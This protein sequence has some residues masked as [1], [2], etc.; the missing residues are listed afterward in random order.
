MA[1]SDKRSDEPRSSRLAYRSVLPAFLLILAFAAVVTVLLSRDLGRNDLVGGDEGYYGV[2]ARNILED[3]SY[4]INPSLSPLGRPGD[5]PFLYP[6]ILSASLAM[7]GIGEVPLRMVSLVASVLTGLL[8]Y[9]TACLLKDNRTGI[10]SALIYLSTPLIANTGRQVA[11]EPVLVTFSMA[12]VF[13]F[14]LACR[15]DRLLPSFIAG[16]FFGA[17]FLCK[18]WL[19]LIPAFGV[20][21]GMTLY[22]LAGSRSEEWDYRTFPMLISLASG[23]LA[24]GSMQLVL[25]AIFTPGNLGHWLDV[26]FGFSLIS[27]ATGEGFASYWHRPWHFYLVTLAR[28]L[29]LWLPLLCIGLSALV[30]SRRRSPSFMIFA[31]WALP[32]IPMSILPVKSGGYI[33][34]FVPVLIIAAGVGLMTIIN[35]DPARWRTT[36]LVST[37]IASLLV[38]SSQVYLPAAGRP[39]LH[40]P[41]IFLIQISWILAMIIATYFRSVFNIRAGIVILGLLFMTMAAGLYRDLEITK[42]VDHATG[43]RSIA[44]SA[45]PILSG[46]DP[47]TPCFIS[48]EWPAI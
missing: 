21:T 35:L 18:L 43:Y 38:L 2:M 10:Y 32:L 29:S 33:L 22:G 11:A 24:T 14:L 19:A 6:L 30:K 41:A 26:Y 31:A 17:A 48:P 9:L 13:L 20:V 42:S 4:I 23:F 47:A 40:S 44:E 1:Y 27:R 5:K 15:R 45:A 3:P 12:G 36:L 8:I 39:V 25:C 7:G 28:S 46:I 34:P 37:G 16:L